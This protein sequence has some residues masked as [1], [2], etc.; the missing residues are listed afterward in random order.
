MRIDE[1]PMR[2]LWLDW[3]HILKRALLLLVFF[4][5]LLGVAYPFLVAGVGKVLFS[6]QAAGSMVV[7][8]G[9]TVGSKL[10]GQDFSGTAYFRSRPSATLPPYNA[11]ASGATNFGPANPQ[12]LSLAIDRSA[13]WHRLVGNDDPVPN[14]LLTAS[15]SGL[16]PHISV[17][18]ARYQIPMV[19]RQTGIPASRLQELIAAHEQRGFFGRHHYVNVLLLNLDVQALMHSQ[20]PQE[21]EQRTDA[22]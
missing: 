13:Q 6:Q 3:L 22:R 5:V 14:E 8:D 20:P 11:A 4:L 16:D 9:K 7:V 17:A 19:V 15:A 2:V 21:K 1:Q 12:L 18:A 10:I